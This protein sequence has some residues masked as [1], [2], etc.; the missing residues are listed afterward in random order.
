MATSCHAGSNRV[1]K[2]NWAGRVLRQRRCQDLQNIRP[3]KV[4]VCVDSLG[5]VVM[6][7]VDNEAVVRMNISIIPLASPIV[8]FSGSR[9]LPCL[10]HGSHF[11]IPT[12][13]S[14]ERVF[15]VSSCCYGAVAVAAAK[16]SSSGLWT[17]VL[18]D[19]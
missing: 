17:F 10:R 5:V 6:L 14:S 15:R 1:A 18:Y 16:S 9:T 12:S 19:Y 3:V 11:P 4:N 2:A 13:G 8:T 7:R